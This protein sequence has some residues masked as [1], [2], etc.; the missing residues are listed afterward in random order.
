M[1]HAHARREESAG[2]VVTQE[3]VPVDEKV[4]A[5]ARVCPRCEAP[6]SPA[7]VVQTCVHCK[8]PFLLVAGAALDASIVP[9]VEAGAKTIKLKYADIALRHAAFVDDKGISH[10]EL[11]PVTGHIPMGTRTIAFGDVVTLG[12][13]RRVAW[14]TLVALVLLYFVPVV[15]PLFAFSIEVPLLLTLALPAFALFLLGVRKATVI[16]VQ[17]MRVTG[18]RPEDTLVFRIDTP[19]WRRKKFLAAVTDR[20]G[21][22]ELPWP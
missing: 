7:R 8:K 12:V 1:G 4:L 11:D 17:R 13:Q 15:A 9:K 6:A 21:V 14:G 3:L 16:G 20:T 10:S 22:G 2:V 19:M 5:R 18:R